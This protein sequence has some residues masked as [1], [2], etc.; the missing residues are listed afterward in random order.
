V[1]ANRL[2]LARAG[3]T[4][5]RAERL[6]GEILTYTAEHAADDGDREAL[7]L[8]LAHLER[9]RAPAREARP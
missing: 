8:I 1:S 4:A 5:R 7:G 9:Y 6:Y 2:D 3:V